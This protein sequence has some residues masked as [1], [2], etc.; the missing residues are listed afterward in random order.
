MMA[1]E[2]TPRDDEVCTSSPRRPC[3]HPQVPA[4]P[5]HAPPTHTDATRLLR[6]KLASAVAMQPHKVS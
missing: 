4:H 6:E 2:P 1:R 3:F 5:P